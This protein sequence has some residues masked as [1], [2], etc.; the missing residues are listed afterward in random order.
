M[1][2][3][4]TQS[5]IAE[6]CIPTCC[7][8]MARN[9]KNRLERAEVAIIKAM[10]AT[11][12]RKTDQDI[13]AYFT[14]PTRSINHGR[15][16][17]IRD[18]KT[19]GTVVPATKE[20]LAAFLEAWPNV[21]GSG[22]HLIGDELLIK[23]REAML[24]AVQGFNN[25]RS[26]FKSEVFIVTAVIA[27]TYLMHAHFRRVGVDYRYRDRRT[28]EVLRTRHGAEKHW[29]LENCL[30]DANC[31]LDVATKANLR[32]LIGIRHEIEHQMTRRIDDYISA[33]LQACC[34][35]FN[36]ALRSIF[37]AEYGLD[38]ELGIALQFA[39]IAKNQ[40]DLLLKDT[41][42]PTHFI[43]AHTAYEDGLADE[44]I[45]DP[46]YAYRV[47]YIERSVN[48]KGRAD[49]VI[50]FIR[51]DTAEG[52]EI[53]RVL[54]K[55]AERKKYKPKDII[56]IM[57]REGHRE[58]NQHA[59]QLLWKSADAKILFTSLASNY[60]PTTGGGTKNGLSTFDRRSPPARRAS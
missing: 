12:A 21:D 58:F 56:D 18:G 36:A 49:Q 59:H 60:D 38:H 7:E 22:L 27:W 9:P 28:G 44:V 15:I 41:D 55:E 43:S 31:P 57:R 11:T 14:R 32:F 25:P 34:L 52:Q 1:N 26:Y 20:E 46:K 23:A 30:A 17:D 6:S 4:T 53:A 8:A 39:G 33:K 10:M 45:R 47:A 51:P 13:L 3:F 24:H 19:H 35:N 5:M 54:V 50:E 48:S 37:G 2:I 40:R 42:L 29:E 16:K